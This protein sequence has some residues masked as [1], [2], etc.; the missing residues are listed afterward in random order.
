MQTA[1]ALEKVMRT[2]RPGAR[3]VAAGLK[4]APW[5]AL[6]INAF[7]RAA[8]LRSVTTLAGLEEPWQRLGT[9]MS[10]VSVEKLMGG[11]IYIAS[12]VRG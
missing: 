10:E 9:Y 5:W 3:V 11:G 8:A 12:G 2:L 6:A 4:W 1:A 7:V